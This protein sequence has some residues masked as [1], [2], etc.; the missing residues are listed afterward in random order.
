[1]AKRKINSTEQVIAE[2]SRTKRTEKVD[3]ETYSR[4]FAEKKTIVAKLKNAV[5]IETAGHSTRTNFFLN[6]TRELIAAIKKQI[7][8][9]RDEKK[10]TEKDIHG[11]ENHTKAL[12]KV[13]TDATVLFEHYNAI[14]SEL[15]TDFVNLVK[16]LNIQEALVDEIMLC[17]RL[18]LYLNIKRE[19]DE[20]ERDIKTVEEGMEQPTWNKFTD[21]FKTIDNQ[22][23][24]FYNQFGDK[25]TSDKLRALKQ[26]G[27]AP[28]E[29]LTDLKKMKKEAGEKL[30]K[31]HTEI[32][33]EI[34]TVVRKLKAK[35][36]TSHATAIT[37]LV[38]AGGYK[39]E[40]LVREQALA[41]LHDSLLQEE[42][43]L[44]KA[45]KG[46]TLEE[47]A[48][49]QAHLAVIKAEKGLAILIKREGEIL[50]WQ[51]KLVE[52]TQ[53]ADPTENHRNLTPDDRAVQIAKLMAEADH[54]ISSGVVTN[55]LIP[56]L[57]DLG[58]FKSFINAV[59]GPKLIERD[60]NLSANESY[61]KIADLSRYTEILDAFK[62][63]EDEG[64]IR[65]IEKELGLPV[66]NTNLSE[67]IIEAV[68][69]AR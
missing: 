51:E 53:L 29:W 31:V 41:G 28:N 49:H 54:P 61:I 48:I 10:L 62:Q 55:Q 19:G 21:F 11:I 14:A 44:A 17:L 20:L 38:Q 43:L 64:G 66:G 2:L 16:Q 24:D 34:I 22:A 35:N 52:A 42:G 68:K 26:H 15:G 37:K 67:R 69:R 59:M 36:L 3:I 6:E 32:D 27:D 25:P 65:E 60:N 23:T 18:E 12:D 57:S 9:L 13:K 56:A 58:N 39:Q 50:G 1:M 63:K 8:V 46:I 47:V 33:S 4:S 7:I 5:P 40:K 45:S 30:N